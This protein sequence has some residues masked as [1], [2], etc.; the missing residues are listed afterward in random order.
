M[1]FS[2]VR[3]RVTKGTMTMAE[4]EFDFDLA[5]KIEALAAPV[6]DSNPYWICTPGG[7]YETNNGNDWCADCGRAMFKHLRRKDKARRADYFFDGGWSGIES[8][9]P[10]FCAH[11]YKP[12]RVSL[13]GY[14]IEE[15]LAHYR[16]NGFN[17]AQ[18]AYEA[19]SIDRLMC[20]ASWGDDSAEEI[21]TLAR[22]FVTAVEANI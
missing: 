1:G 15:E 11:C 2:A 8:D 17:V 7:E 21:Q 3:N 10:R 19:Y 5:K 12:L 4:C 18:V 22:D 6:E 9:S 16:E 20:A 13:T 14:G